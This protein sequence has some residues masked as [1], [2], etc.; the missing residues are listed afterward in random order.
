MVKNL[1]ANAG[2]AGSIPGIGRCPGERN[3]N[4]LQCS[5]LRNP[6]DSGAW[7]TTVHGI[8]KVSDTTEQLKTTTA[9][10]IYTQRNEWNYSSGFQTFF[11]IEKLNEKEILLQKYRKRE[12]RRDRSLAVI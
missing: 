10:R 4:P 12:R 2:D 5:C 1:P 3:G 7:W 11:S 8:V 6:L 9:N